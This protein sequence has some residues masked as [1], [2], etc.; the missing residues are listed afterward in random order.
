MKVKALDR[1]YHGALREPGDEFDVP[2]GSKA[3]WFE[4]TAPE[5][6]KKKPEGRKKPEDAP[7][8]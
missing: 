6:E 2:E 3:T 8:A 4:P 7:L 1:G 5:V